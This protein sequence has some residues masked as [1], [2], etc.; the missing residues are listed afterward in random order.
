VRQ[1][2]ADSRIGNH[3]FMATPLG[4]RR[5]GARSCGLTTEFMMP[6][7]KD[8]KRVVRARMKKTGESYTTARTHVASQPPPRARAV[9]ETAKAS[10]TA[11]ASPVDYARLAGRSD[12]VLKAKTGCTWEKWVKALD[13]HGA[14]QMSHGEIAKLVHEKYKVPSWWTQTVTVG[15]ERI[16]GLR[17]IGQQRDGSYEATKSRTFDAPLSE[18]YQAFAD[19]DIRRR[20]FPE[21]TFTVRSSTPGKRMRIVREDKS[22]VQVEFNA[23]G[24]AKSQVAIQHGKLPDKDAS[25]KMKA[26]WS[27]R[28]DALATILKART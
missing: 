11:T 5:W 3:D 2:G 27:E 22:V 20:W 14:Q 6:T 8:F 24:A 17:A 9:R 25:T 10:N 21:A 7:N 12:A 13:H 18:L 26:F 15:Y 23:K 16:R 19:K 28:L 4:R 1:R